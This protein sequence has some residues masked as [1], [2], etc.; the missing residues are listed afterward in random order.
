VF[1]LHN[2]RMALD[3]SEACRTLFGTLEPAAQSGTDRQDELGAAL[4]AILPLP[5]LHYG[6]NYV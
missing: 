4:R 2:E 3:R 6:I 5:T 1:A